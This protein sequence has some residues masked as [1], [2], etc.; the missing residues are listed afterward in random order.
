MRAAL[1]FTLFLFSGAIAQN[2]VVLKLRADSLFEAQNFE[3]A[4]E[5]YLQIAKVEPGNFPALNGAAQAQYH[6]KNYERTISICN[7]GFRP[8]LTLVY[9]IIFYR[10]KGMSYYYLDNNLK[11]IDFL[12][13]S[14]EYEMD[15]ESYQLKALANYNLY[16][17]DDAIVDANFCL[18]DRNA[19][20]ES[21]VFSY[22]L[23]GLS[24]LKKGDI[25]KAKEYSEKLNK[26]DSLNPRAAVLR[27][28]IACSEGDHEK[29]YRLWAELYEGDT[30]NL[31]NLYQMAYCRMESKKWEEALI[32][33][34]KLCTAEYEVADVTGKIGWS[35]YLLGKYSDAIEFG[36]RAIL[37]DPKDFFAFKT[38]GCGYYGLK[39]YDLAIADFN[40]G[41]RLDKKVSSLHYYRG[42]CYLKTNKVDA[43][44]KDWNIVVNADDYYVQDGETSP[45]KLIEKN[46]KK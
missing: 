1:Y 9:K 36:N 30:T 14:L 13:K 34:H 8:D 44:C 45:E 39:K 2:T 20:L 32:I 5:A 16:R 27:A 35:Y 7:M 21:D 17:Y 23:I 18:K 15:L 40:A 29:S 4:T 42:L 46:C 22:Q 31:Y 6:L 25:E 19:D 11:A 37:A 28:T 10:F 26:K 3:K 38:R 41:M 33:L 43:A 12:G 24:Y